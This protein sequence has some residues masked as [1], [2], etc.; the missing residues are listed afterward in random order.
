MKKYTTGAPNF[1][2]TAHLEPAPISEE[3]LEQVKKIVFHALDSLGIR[4]SASHSELK[5]SKDGQINLI[6]IG[7]RMGGDCIGSGLVELS[8]GVDFVQAVIQVALGEEPYLMPKKHNDYAAVRFILNKEDVKV[9]ERVMK[10]NSEIVVEHDVQT[11]G[12]EKVTDS[13]TRHGYFI[14]NAD[15]RALIEKYLPEDVED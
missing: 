15:S 9:F 1:I 2:E 14:I 5:I 11:V 6:E 12:S 7:G 13:S 8:T 4:N 3:L 10:E